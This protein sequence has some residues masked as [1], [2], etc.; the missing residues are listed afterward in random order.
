MAPGQGAYTAAESSLRLVFRRENVQS[1]SMRPL[2]RSSNIASFWRVL[3][4]CGALFI[5]PADVQC[6]SPGT[7]DYLIDVWSADNGL[8][9]SSVTAIAQTL[10]GYLWIGTYNGLARFDGV[11]FVTFDP[12]NTPALAHAGVR[13]LSVDDRGTLWINTFDGSLTSLRNGVFAREWTGVEGQVRSP[14][15]TLV[16]SASNH[17]TFLFRSGELRRKS[18]DAAPGMGWEVLTSTNR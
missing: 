11:R 3:G 17:V 18:Q 15:I 8:R 5:S 10:D 6:A 2:P 16:S 7:G 13:K 14:D 9:S 4:C 12:A 1:A